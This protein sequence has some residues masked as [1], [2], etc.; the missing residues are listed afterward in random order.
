MAVQFFQTKQWRIGTTQM[1]V[2]RGKTQLQI[3]AYARVYLDSTLTEVTTTF[4]LVAE[5]VTL[6]L[7]GPGGA[8]Y[9]VVTK[10]LWEFGKQDILNFFTAAGQVLPPNPS[11][12]VSPPGIHGNSEYEAVVTDG[13]KRGQ[14]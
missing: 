10:E 1:L 6:T 13:T 3:S 4:T 2:N 8:S 11:V 5:T 7:G 14:T 12:F 9:L